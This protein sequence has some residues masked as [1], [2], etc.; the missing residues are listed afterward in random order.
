MPLEALLRDDV[1]LCAQ[2]C[3]WDA[4]WTRVIRSFAKT[5]WLAHSRPTHECRP[6]GEST[7]TRRA[8]ALVLLCCTLTARGAVT[9]PPDFEP[10][11]TRTTGTVTV[12]GSRIDYRAVAGTL[13]VHPKGW[14]PNAAPSDAKNP[15]AEAS[16]FYV[17]Y[18][19]RGVPAADRPITFLF[20]GG[21]G[22]SSVWLHMGAFG[23]IR[24]VTADH[25]HTPPAPYR[26]VNNGESLLDASDLV[27]ID[28]PGT[29]FS[30]IGGPNAD[31]SFYGV[32]QDI[33]AFAVFIREFLSR[34]DRWNSPKYV[35]GESYGTMRAA[36]LALALQREDIDLNGVMLQSLILDWDLMPDDPRLNPSVDLPYV[37]TLPSYAATAWYHHVLPG[38]PQPLR[39]LLDKV[40][41][42]AT[43]DYALALMRGNQLSAAKRQS[44]AD[45]LH[46]DT[47]LP[48]AYLLKSDLRIEYGA[49]QK[50][51]LANQDLTTGTLDTRFTGPTLDPLSRL[52]QYDP[53][54]A[55]IS[56]AYVSAF[57]A[58]VRERLHYGRGMDYRP[59]IPVYGRWDYRHQPPGAP[60]A[61]IALP[62]VLPDL[63]VAMKRNPDLQVM[64]NSGYFDLSTPYYE[65][66]FELHHLPIPP[67]LQRNIEYRYYRSGHMIYVHGPA[68]KQLHANVAAFIQRTDHLQ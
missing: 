35:Y 16:M 47:G 44:I 54:S 20:N 13:V 32:D 9:A 40:E 45:R 34:Y 17:A 1:T 56:S 52:S 50:E 12:N 22:S 51:L 65:G 26:L 5:R 49:F 29:G 57:N 19:R 4:H 10:T 6:P 42:F 43:T 23:P 48:V 66:W 14:N 27:F 41:R 38:P 7:M 39:V 64:V 46:A 60:R 33:H 55:A 31:K 25:E 11:E 3:V 61:L 18:F 58:Y 8:L 28:A 36:G 67:S 15:A 62:N 2:S 21:P 24:V 63:A 37:V 53:Q 30:R 59:G 68:R